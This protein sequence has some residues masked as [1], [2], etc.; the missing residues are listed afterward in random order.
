MSPNPEQIEPTPPENDAA[1]PSSISVPARFLANLPPDVRATL[2]PDVQALLEQAAQAGAVISRHS[3]HTSV[4]MEMAPGNRMNPI[5]SQVTSEHISEII[6][7]R[8]KNSDQEHSLRKLG[9]AFA[10]FLVLVV[11]GI[12]VFMTVNERPDLLR[13]II[14]GIGG[15]FSGLVAGIGG[16]YGYANRR[17]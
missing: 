15:L 5:L 11:V 12:I 9:F 16:G 1:N 4:S 14:F 8:G 2:P 6:K 10:G 17:R 13:E 7:Q 3:S